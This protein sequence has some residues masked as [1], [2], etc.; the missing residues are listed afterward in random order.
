MDEVADVLMGESGS[1][2]G[3]RTLKLDLQWIYSERQ[4]VSAGG[5]SARSSSRR[6]GNIHD[7]KTSPGG[8]CRDC[9]L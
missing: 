2:F 7:P 9:S 8:G 5:Y 4:P 6:R 3:R 1:A